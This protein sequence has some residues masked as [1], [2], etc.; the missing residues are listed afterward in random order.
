MDPIKQRLVKVVGTKRMLL[1]D[2][3]S[4]SEKLKVYSTG[5]NYQSLKGDFG[6]FQLST[7]DGNIVIPNIKYPEPLKL[8]FEH[9]ISCIKEEKA[10]KTNME[11][12]LQVVQILEAVTRSI[13]LNGKKIAIK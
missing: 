11:S 5:K 3:V 4:T 1:F 13:K 10:P 6:S 9:F 7:N 12:G 2:D 8:E